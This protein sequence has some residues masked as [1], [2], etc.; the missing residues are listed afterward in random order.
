MRSL[1]GLSIFL[2]LSIVF[3]SHISLGQDIPEITAE[4]FPELTLN[5]N[6]CFDGESLWGYMNGG[7][8]IYLE[9]GFKVLR[10]EEFSTGDETIKLELYKMDDPISA[11]GIFSIKTFKCDQVEVSTSPDCLN[12][13][14][15][16]LLFGD[17]YLQLINESGSEKAQ[18]LMIV[19]ADSI[20]QKLEQGELIIPAKYLTDGLDFSLYDIKMIKGSLGIRNKTTGLADYF[21][22]IEG[23]QI[24][25]AKMLIDGE[26]VKYYEV[27]FDTP[28]MKDLFLDKNKNKGVQVIY[29]S[30]NSIV[31]QQKKQ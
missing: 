24:Y 19:I 4:E 16:Q 8:D 13:F 29:T 6:D 1:S 27:L 17:Y 5:R 25:Y 26:K 14:Q 21:E 3:C 30:P 28:K 12:R 15:F 9:Y 22:S 20:L 31:I 18:Q 23:Y 10:V 7:A 11:F 2:F